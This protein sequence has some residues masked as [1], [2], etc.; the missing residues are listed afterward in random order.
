MRS[1][2]APGSKAINTSATEASLQAE[3]KQRLN[4]LATWR[5]QEQSQMNAEKTAMQA[6]AEQAVRAA[7]ADASLRAEQQFQMQ[8][9]Q[10]ACQGAAAFENRLQ[11]THAAHLAQ[12][13]KLE[14]DLEQLRNQA[15]TR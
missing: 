9:K 3:L 8:L 6:Q 15:T 13:K 5:V 2:S 1:H 4:D 14:H 10:A 7:A 12:Q 11:Q